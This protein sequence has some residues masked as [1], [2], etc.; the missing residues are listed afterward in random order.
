M[1]A[2]QHPRVAVLAAVALS[3][4]VAACS[5]D[6]AAPTALP[7]S[8]I[9]ASVRTDD[10][11]LTIGVLTPQG[12]A[13]A[14]IGQAIRTAVTMAVDT[15]NKA[16]GYN[17]RAVVLRP[18]DEGVA[19]VGIDPAIATLLDEQVD[20]IVG[21]ASSS[22]ALAGLGEIVHAGVVACSP[23]ASARLL[24][25]FPDQNLF[26]RTIP[27]DSMQALAIAEAVDRTGASRATVTYIDDDYGQ[28]FADSVK[29]SLVLKG[30]EQEAVIPYSADNVSIKAAASKVVATAAGVVV[31]IGDATSGPVMLGEIDSQEL[32]VSP[33]FVVN[34]A[35]RR[36]TASAE[37]MGVSLSSRVR[38]IS[39]VAYS[40]NAQFLAQLGATP[41]DPSP[42]AANAFDCVN[43]IA[44]AALAGD[45]TQPEVIARQI[46]LVS[47]SGSPCMTFVDCRDD[48]AA[49]SNIN[50]DGPGGTLTIGT[51]GDLASAVFDLFGFDE[52]GRDVNVGTVRCSL[53]DCS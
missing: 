18:A 5:S 44:L 29:A 12:S 22:N 52:T 48:I 40:S 36:P 19:G 45:S 27:S 30:I 31:V 33:Q 10:G 42:Y 53:R 9:A 4:A 21:P 24:D 49:G 37:P 50:Y 16:G 35:M 13:N 51:D 17:G 38:G 3:V 28:A 20:A 6:S 47:D 39:P 23:T 8:T 26:F 32:D 41:D 2:S 25:D 1:P 7:A 34:D 43:L 14:D 15:I 11:V 46:P